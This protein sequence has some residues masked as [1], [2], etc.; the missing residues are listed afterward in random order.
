MQSVQRA[1]A[2][3]SH[4]VTCTGPSRFIPSRAQK[5]SALDTAPAPLIIPHPC[6]CTYMFSPSPSPSHRQQLQLCTWTPLECDSELI[7]CADQ[8]HM[9]SDFNECVG[10]LSLFSPC[11]R[12]FH[13]VHAHRTV[14]RKK[15]KH[16][17]QCDVHI[18]IITLKW[19]SLPLGTLCDP[20]SLITCR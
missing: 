17:L 20:D 16:T 7:W 9:H 15:Q 1:E 13:L 11:G 5:M 4:C 19:L 18:I 3:Y 14:F 6:T 8:L 10:P 2:E 12:C